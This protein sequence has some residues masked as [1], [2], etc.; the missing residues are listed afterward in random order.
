M[1]TA[2][3]ISG[4]WNDDCSHKWVDRSKR[5]LPHDYLYT[6]SWKGQNTVDFTVDHFF[7]E[8]ENEYH[9]V[10]DT[11]AYPD[12]ASALRRD[13]FPQLI[14]E[15]EAGGSSHSEL[16]HALASQNWHKQILIHN[17]M[18]KQLPDDIDMVIRTRFDTIVSDQLDWQGMIRESYDQIVPMGFNC[19]N[20]YGTHDFN[21]IRGMGK[22]TTYYINDALIIHPRECWD[23]DLVD[24]L[25]KDKKLKSAEEG[26]YQILSEPFGMYHQSYHGG[27]YLSGRWEYVRDVD[28]SLHN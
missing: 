14:K 9:P 11:E 6:G 10:F 13:V 1:K 21:R 3:C 8:P 12:D 27:C 26:W 4:R 15:H 24:R 19:M 17:E 2:L 20:Y 18:M 25:Y 22:E 28:E 5:L 16:K 23:T 7:D